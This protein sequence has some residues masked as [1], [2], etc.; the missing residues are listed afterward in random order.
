[1]NHYYKKL[2]L[3][4]F[5]C[6]LFG[7]SNLLKANCSFAS[8]TLDQVVQN[9]DGSYDITM[10]FCA[11]GGYDGCTDITGAFGFFVEGGAQ[12]IGFTPTLTSPQTGETFTGEIMQYQYPSDVVVYHTFG[13]YIWWTCVDVGCGPI[14]PVCAQVTITTD[15]LPSKV[16]CGG[17]EGIG[18]LVAPYSC[19]GPNLEVF[20]DPNFPP[21]PC[22]YFDLVADAGDDVNVMYSYQGSE[23]T[24]LSASTTGSGTAPYSYL[25]SDGS[26]TSSIGV[27]PSTTTTYSVTITDNDGCTTSDD[28]TVNVQDIFCGN[29]KVYM[30]KPNGTTRCIKLNRVQSKLNAGWTLGPCGS[31]N[32]KVPNDVFSSLTSEQEYEAS[33]RNQVIENRKVFI[34]NLNGQMVGNFEVSDKDNTQYYLNQMNIPRGIYI[35]MYK[36]EDGDMTS[37]KVFKF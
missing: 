35:Q 36:D 13:A 25:W 14:V 4:L 9:N 22:Y 2:F 7:S 31:N 8:L 10:T 1:M 18:V 12:I 19:T 30:C 37:E 5:I 33:G 17:M 29:N 23:C 32:I 27:C 24:T 11:T 15:V 21:P 6:L 34:Y 20:P 3:S 16:I 28:V 26:T